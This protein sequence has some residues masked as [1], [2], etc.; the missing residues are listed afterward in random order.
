MNQTYQ[1]F[2]I[3]I[4][5]DAS[6]DASLNL[7]KDI[8]AK[9]ERIRL[10][11][12]QDNAGVSVN[13]NQG[14]EKAR[15]YYVTFMDD[16][17]YLEPEFLSKMVGEAEKADADIVTCN[18]IKEYG[19]KKIINPYCVKEK[20]KTGTIEELEKVAATVIDPKTD[21]TDMQ[22]LMLGSAWGKLYKRDFLLDNAEIRFPGGMMGGEDAV[23]F[24]K[25]L[26]AKKPPVLKM[27][28]D[29]LY[30][31][32]KNEASYTV[33][34]QP[35][36]PEENLARIKMFYSL[37]QGHPLMEKAT[38]RNVC[39]AIMD[40]CSVYLTAPECPVNNKRKFLKETLS[41]PEYKKALDDL[42]NLGYDFGKK[43]IYT[44]A[45]LGILTPV[46]L[47]GKL[48]RNSK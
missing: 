14:I 43:M 44:C 42:S 40:M 8:A 29:A 31:Y 39:Y 9:D 6:N 30:V 11:S 35:K 22:L 34:F 17:D 3:L 10:Y 18:F 19:D 46:L 45:K 7:L 16:D 27:I 2:E 26:Q 37:S 20:V 24:I 41:L 32:R 21:G 47:A 15:G 23:F 13:R 36:L 48:Y 1:D 25:A 28:S 5:D 12:R 4:M 38:K 33:G